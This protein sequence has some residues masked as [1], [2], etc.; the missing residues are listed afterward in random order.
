[1]DNFEENDYGF[2]DFGD[3]YSNELKEIDRLLKEENKTE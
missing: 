1:M 2:N 3:T